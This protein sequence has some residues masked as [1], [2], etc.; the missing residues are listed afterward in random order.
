[1]CVLHVNSLNRLAN[2]CRLYIRSFVDNVVLPDNI[3]QAT[4]GHDVAAN[5]A[6]CFS[7]SMIKLEHVLN[8]TFWVKKSVTDLQLWTI[9]SVCTIFWERNKDTTGEKPI[10]ICENNNANNNANDRRNI[11]LFIRKHIWIEKRGKKKDVR[12]ILT[13]EW[14]KLAQHDV[15]LRTINNKIANYTMTGRKHVWR[16][17]SW[18]L[19]KTFMERYDKTPT[20]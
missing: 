2:Q 9:Y 1:M 4:A 3:H 6:K 8:N 11:K 13:F 5:V 18:S 14:K 17:L 16:I 10:I 20:S 15:P 12:K 7:C 19:N